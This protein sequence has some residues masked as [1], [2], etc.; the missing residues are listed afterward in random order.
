MFNDICCFN[1]KKKIEISNPCSQCVQCR[2]GEKT[3]IHWE[4]FWSFV[5]ACGTRALALAHQCV[6]GQICYPAL[7][8]LGGLSLFWAGVN[9]VYTASGQSWTIMALLYI[10]KHSCKFRI[11]PQN[12][13]SI[14]AQSSKTGNS[15]WEASWALHLK[16]ITIHYCLYSPRKGSFWKWYL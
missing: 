12:L 3:L 7:P 9:P 8:P 15:A 14:Q 4:V 6:C 11:L 13:G 2:K 10:T 5:C 1:R 16:Y